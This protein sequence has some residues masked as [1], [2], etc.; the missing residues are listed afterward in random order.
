MAE[1]V[2][3]WY[4]RGSYF[5]TEQQARIHEFRCDAQRRLATM[6]PVMAM[7]YEV[8]EL[9]IIHRATILEILKDHP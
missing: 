2:T 8:A 7:P 1:Q 5:E 4:A 6:F 3:R 9:I